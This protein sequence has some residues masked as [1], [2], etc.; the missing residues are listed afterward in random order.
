[1][2]KLKST[3][4]G[5]LEL[6]QERG[7]NFLGKGMICFLSDSQ[8][9]LSECLKMCVLKN[10]SDHGH[11]L[12]KHS[13]LST[14]DITNMRLLCQAHLPQQRALEFSFT[15]L[16]VLGLKT[17]TVNLFSFVVCATCLY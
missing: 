12:F 14:E 16:L 11:P 8:C 1:M 3:G 10:T 13:L 15:V 17:G 2:F 9:Q 5:L 7:N 4:E 6:S